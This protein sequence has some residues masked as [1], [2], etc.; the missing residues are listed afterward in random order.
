MKQTH[1][2]KGDG[3]AIKYLLDNGFLAEPFDKGVGFKVLKKGT[4]E[5]KLDGL[6]QADL[7]R[8]FDTQYYQKKRRIFF[9]EKLDEISEALYTRLRSM[10]THSAM[11]YFKQCTSFYLLVVR[12][13][14]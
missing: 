8:E 4:C 1:S 3:K 12:M 14:T 13:S 9:D 6:L 11:L 5:I 2:E 10:G 7:C